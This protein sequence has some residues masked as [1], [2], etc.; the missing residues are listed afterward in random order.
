[1]SKTILNATD[2]RND[3]FKLIDLVAESKKP[4]FIK[5]DREIKVRLV[6]VNG[7]MEKDWRETEKLLDEVWGM[8][9]DKSEEELTGR[10]QEADLASTKAIRARNRNR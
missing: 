10:F 5:K 6:P 7:E 8:W 9:A 2:V 3:F 1:M 4:I